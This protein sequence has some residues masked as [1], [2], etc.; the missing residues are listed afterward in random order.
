MKKIL[1]CGLMAATM[2]CGQLAAEPVAKTVAVGAGQTQAT[3]AVEPKVNINTASEDE[4]V[5][6]KG[7]GEKKARAIVEYRTANGKF[8][9]I[10]EVTR[11][12]GLGAKF[13]EQ[14]RERLSL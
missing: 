3:Q 8:T 7:I 10:E 14:N 5:T 6:L 12:S 4:L 9:S 13:L 11:V 1:L 2:V